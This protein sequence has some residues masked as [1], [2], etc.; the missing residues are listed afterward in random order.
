M[1]KDDRRLVPE[2]KTLIDGIAG[3]SLDPDVHTVPAQGGVIGRKSDRLDV[4]GE[5]PPPRSRSQAEGTDTSSA[6][7]V[8]DLIEGTREDN[9][10][11]QTVAEKAMERGS[12][13]S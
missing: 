5:A 8:V 10:T 6:A 4:A 9:L 1:A 11:N 3:D 2:G 13:P 12:G 7:D